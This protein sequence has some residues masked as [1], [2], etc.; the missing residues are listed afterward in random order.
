MIV[1][2]QMIV[3][4]VRWGPHAARA[5]SKWTYAVHSTG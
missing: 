4:Q 2:S 3:F 5:R 1:D